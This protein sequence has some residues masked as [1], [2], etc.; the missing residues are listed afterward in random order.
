MDDNTEE[1]VPKKNATLVI[2]QSTVICKDCKDKVCTSDGN[3]TNL[4]K[5]LK[6]KAPETVCKQSN[7]EGIPREG[8]NYNHAARGHKAT[9]NSNKGIWERHS[10]W[11]DKYMIPITAVENQDFKRPLKTVD[12]LYEIPSRKYFSNTAIPQQYSECRRKIQHKI[13]KVKFHWYNKW[14]W[15]FISFMTVE[16]GQCMLG[17]WE[18]RTWP[19]W[20][21]TVLHEIL[22]EYSYFAQFHTWLKSVWKGTL[23][24]MICYSFFLLVFC[25]LVG[26][27][28]F[29]TGKLVWL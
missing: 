13:Q 18:R 21:Q 1:L 23:A 11:H 2:L 9:N 12:R 29:K 24:R 20:P 15:L 16:A 28:F 27:Y 3:T 8:T 6:K 10:V 17:G 19:P 4:F 25:Y 22:V 5:H 26:L 14:F 7:S